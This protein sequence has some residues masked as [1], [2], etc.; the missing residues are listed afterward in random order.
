MRI[1]DAF[2]TLLNVLLTV[3]LVLIFF[4]FAEIWGAGHV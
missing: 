2:D 1:P 3:L 4:L